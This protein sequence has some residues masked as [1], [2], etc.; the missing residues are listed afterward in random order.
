MATLDRGGRPRDTGRRPACPD[1]H[2]GKITFHGYRK[3]TDG[4]YARPRYLCDHQQCGPRCRPTCK[5]RHTFTGSEQ[6]RT[7]AHPEGLWCRECDRERSLRDGTPVGNYWDF[8]ARLIADALIAVGAG[9]SYRSAAVGMRLAARRV[10]HDAKGV[11]YASKAGETVARY[12]DH[13]G[14]LALSQFEH[15]E[16]PEVL[17]LDALPLWRREVVEGDPFSFE[18]SDNGAILFAVGYTEPVSHRRRRRRTDE[19]EQAGGPARHN[20]PRR[21][22]HLWRVEVAGGH[23]RWSWF[24]FLSS[25][26]GT[27]KWIVVDGDSAV[28][29]AIKLRWGT[30]PDAPIIY[31]CE[32]HLQNRFRER[33]RDEDHLT[34]HEIWKL[35]PKHKRGSHDGPPG[36][37]WSRDDYRRLLDAVLAYPPERVKN[38]TSWIAYHDETIRRQFDLRERHPGYPRGTGATEAASRRVDLW[39]GDRWKTFQN[40]RRINITL[41]L[42]R[43][44]IAGHADPAACSRVIR[45]ELERTNGRPRLDWRQFH[46]PWALRKGLFHLSDAAVRR[47][48]QD[49][50]RYLINAQASSIAKKAARMNAYHLTNGYPPIE[51]T[52]ARTPSVKVEGK[53]V[54]DFPL[55]ARE[56]DPANK[57][58]PG[59]T[60]AGSTTIVGWV[61][62]HNPPHRWRTK[63]GNRTRRLTG[64]GALRGGAARKATDDP[65]DLAAIRAAWG[66][67]EST[68]ALSA[69][70]VPPEDGWPDDEEPISDPLAY[71]IGREDDLL[72]P[73]GGDWGEQVSHRL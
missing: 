36:P 67:Y 71:E 19:D 10:H 26:G 31:S 60:E 5:G 18:Q 17:V 59:T 54:S 8:E 34:G 65:P 12:L 42:M 63:V 46:N 61:C 23:D 37:L 66:D 64:C 11:P 38:I 2:L 7:H 58:D 32:G 29:F 68:P 4:L 39:I 72:P 41:G 27:P 55:I 50:R 13:F 62:A 45:A 57:G 21:L 44:Q 70:V 20:R 40:V 69:S 47:V 15:P 16:W 73:I 3:R 22:P 56:W 30:G 1:G 53:K 14:E 48:E 24:D 35:W 33:A 43:A 51:L 25:I 28:R 49:R 6:T 52:D 9:A